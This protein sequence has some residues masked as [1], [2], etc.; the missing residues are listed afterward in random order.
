M[1]IAVGAALGCLLLL[2]VIVVL[3]YVCTRSKNRK[4]KGGKK[5]RDEGRI[6]LYPV[7]R[8]CTECRLLSQILVC[9]LSLV[10]KVLS[11]RGNEC[12]KI[13]T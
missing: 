9:M 13:K 2:I 6:P 11:L 3:F 12:E 7:R 10:C 8:V 4:G 1:F 5:D